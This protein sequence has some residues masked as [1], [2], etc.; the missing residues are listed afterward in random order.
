[1]FLRSSN[2]ELTDFLPSDRV[3]SFSSGLPTETPSNHYIN[4]EHQYQSPAIDSLLVAKKRKD[5][6]ADE[7]SPQTPTGSGFLNRRL[8]S[9]SMA[10]RSF[11]NHGSPTRNQDSHAMHMESRIVKEFDTIDA[12]LMSNMTIEI[13]SDYIARERLSSMPHRGSLWDRVLRWAEFYALQIDAYA[14]K[15]SLIHI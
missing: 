11:S 6:A 15:L 13:F 14:K 1:M 4:M 12:T 2:L 10:H 9:S 8:D 5:S 7:P 3:P